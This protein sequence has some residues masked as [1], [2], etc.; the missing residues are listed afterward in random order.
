[1]TAV[2]PATA[3]ARETAISIVINLAFSL[4]FFLLIFGGTGPVTVWGMGQL[5]FDNAIQAFMIAL[6]STLVPGALLLRRLP[7]SLVVRAA[8][9]GL[10][11]A[12]I[13]GGALAAI[14]SLGDVAALAWRDA[15]ILKLTFGAVIAAIV[16]PICLRATSR[17]R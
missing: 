16:T 15:L 5:A 3:I 8:L 13:G 17:S 14:L 11:A 10:A 4:G 2:L 9:A 6:M 1:M 7:G 12:V